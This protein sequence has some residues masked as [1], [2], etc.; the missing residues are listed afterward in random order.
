[1]KMNDQ[2]TKYIE[3]LNALEQMQDETIVAATTARRTM[4]FAASELAYDM[5]GGLK[6]KDMDEDQTFYYK[7]FNLR[8][9]TLVALRVASAWC[10]SEIERHKAMAPDS[11]DSGGS[12]ENENDGE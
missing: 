5:V 12:S 1:M 9:R 10:A 7:K 11:S 3:E 6:V 2:Q 4:P 8:I